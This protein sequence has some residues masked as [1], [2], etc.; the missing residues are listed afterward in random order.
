[1]FSTSVFAITTVSE[2]NLRE[3]VSR[4]P[5][6]RSMRERLAASE[7]IKGSLLRSFLPKVSAT[8]GR[9]KYTTGPYYWVNQ[10]FG[11]IQATM[12]VF[13]SGKD[14]IEN[15]KRSK[16]ASIAAIDASMA[17][18]LVMTEIRKS[19][20]HFA[21]LEEI[22]VILADA[23]GQN[24]TNLKNAQKRI[25]AG[26]GTRT[27]LLDFKQQ[28]VQIEQEIETLVYEQGVALRL[29]STLIGQPVDQALQVQY[30]NSHPEHGKLTVETPTLKNSLI[31]QRATLLSE[32]AQLEKKEA[33]RWWTPNLELY[34]YALRLV[35]KEREYPEPGQR[36]D[37]A[38]GFRFT[39][40]FFDGGEGF[41][42]A[43]KLAAQA[44]A[45]EF[46]AE[47]KQLEVE[48]LASN[49]VNNLKL[50]HRL[51]HG[52]EQNVE[53]MEEYRKG[54]LSEYG[55]GIKN[56]PDVLQANQRWIEAKTRFAEVKKNYQFA[57]ADATYLKEMSAQ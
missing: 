2:Q 20:S 35:Q 30:E 47:A 3:V 22:R 36:N 19:M 8:Y 33:D 57:N 1:M 16:D 13:N 34:S 39:L 18:S 17:R 10:P 43:H 4:S 37:V 28:A 31:L 14:S 12:N 51:I 46:Q 38:F 42:T 48:R 40:P 23:L 49:A 50:A 41:K 24:V 21:Y 11:G 9:E 56:S 25:N 54:I 5:E 55:R 53:L 7:V 52:A 29:I 44:K 15:E 32:V 27:D 26:L 45:V 6:L